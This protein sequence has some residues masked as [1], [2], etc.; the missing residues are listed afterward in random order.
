MPLVVL[1]LFIIFPSLLKI[2]FGK[3]FF[4]F[5]GGGGTSRFEDGYPPGTANIDESDAVGT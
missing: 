4:L 3:M 1:Y 2:K 5:W